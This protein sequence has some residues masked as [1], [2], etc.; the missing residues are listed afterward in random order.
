MDTDILRRAPLQHA[1]VDTARIA[2]RCVGDGPPLL[3]IHGWPFDGTTY[4]ALVPHLAAH[5][6]CYV[7]DTPGLGVSEWT[8]RTD[9]SLPGQAATIGKFA[10]ALGLDGCAIVAHDTGATIARLLAARAPQLVR[11]LVLLNTEMPGHRPP[12]IPLYR[13]IAA[14]PGAAA[15][16]ALTMRLPGFAHSPLGY[17]G[18]F[19]DPARIDAAFL[20]RVAAPLLG[21]RSRLEGALRYLRGI[22]WA[23]IDGLVDTHRRI[24]CQTLL[25]W[26]ADDR[27]FPVAY[28]R[29]L[30]E[31]FR[32]RARLVEIPNACFLV[33]EERPDEVAAAA[34]PFLI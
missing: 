17:G 1:D 2:Y 22:D 21:S 15:G 12:W 27:T 14:L 4:G 25:V 31:Q 11:R 6:R 16:F 3:L 33:H 7:P 13:R 9:F 19:G 26:G 20:A 8:A 34:L 23:V 24:D 30:P 29:R 10:A 5:F 18:C 28:A 32:G